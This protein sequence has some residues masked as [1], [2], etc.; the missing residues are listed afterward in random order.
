V[1]SR[2]WSDAT[3]TGAP[4]ATPENP[5][6]R[7]KNPHDKL[8]KSSAER[9]VGVLRSA[10]SPHQELG[11]WVTGVTTRRNCTAVQVLVKGRSTPRTA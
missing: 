4:A 8:K 11:F 5:S 7:A 10:G 3:V 1:K 6:I 9:R 2:D